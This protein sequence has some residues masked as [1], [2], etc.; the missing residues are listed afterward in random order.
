MSAGAWGWLSASVLLWLAAG[1]MMLASRRKRVD[2]RVR[3]RLNQDG[4]FLDKRR[5]RNAGLTRWLQQ[6]GITLPTWLLLLLVGAALLIALLLLPL[7]W[8][9]PL[10]AL[11]A[12]ALVVYL[13]GQWRAQKRVDRM[14]A[15]MPGFLDHM[16]RSIKSGRTMGDAMLL[17]MRR[18]ADPLQ[19]AMVP[20]RR[21]IELG[22]P[23]A[24]AVS[25]FATLYEREEFHVLALG[26][27]INQRYGGNSSDMLKSLI[28]MIR[29]RERAS[30]Q[31]SAM[32]GETRISAFVLAGLPLA[33]GA[34]ILISNPDFLMG[35]WESGTGRILL[36]V[37]LA[38]QLTGCFILWRML[39][40]I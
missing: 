13:I 6:A 24:E 2:E 28:G 25:E 36:L 19:T 39:K 14:I 37:A 23:M 8:F 29:D 1:M 20:V 30:R 31:L 9:M 17:A 11:G 12:M 4:E 7:G 18:A 35:M 10:I 5:R 38:L 3:A 32:T 26:V 15:Q 34:Y 21:D 27:R 33:L 40:S 16:V 22:V